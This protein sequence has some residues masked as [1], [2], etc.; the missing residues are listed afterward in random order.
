MLVTLTGRLPSSCRFRLLA[1]LA[2]P[3]GHSPII[4]CTHKRHIQSKAVADPIMAT[5]DLHPARSFQ[6]MWWDGGAPRW[7]PHVSRRL[8]LAWPES[9]DGL[10]RPWARRGGCGHSIVE[11]LQAREIGS[12]PVPMPVGP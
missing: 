9:A 12:L 10:P 11:C 7:E 4:L 1:P 5:A 2:K 3:T 6:P 8:Q